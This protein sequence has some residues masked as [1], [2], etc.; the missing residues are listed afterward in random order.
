[1]VIVI[2]QTASTENA[3]LYNEKKVEQKAAV[4]FHS[5][6]TKAINPFFF[7]KSH[8]L[9]EL[10]NIEKLNPRVKNKCLHISV[11]PSADDS[12]KLNNP[13]IRKEIDQFMQHMGYGNQTYFVYKHKDLERTHF[14]IVSTRIDK[15]SGKKV[16]DNHERQKAQNFIKELELRHL[17]D[18]RKRSEK[19]VFKFSAQ[20]R[21]I[22]QS[23]ESLFYHINQMSEV[24]SK[25]LY[26]ETLKLFNVEIRKS[27]RGH[28]VLVTDGNGKVI[29]YPIRLSK[30]KEKPNFYQVEKKTSIK[31]RIAT[32]KD[33]R[34]S[35][36]FKSAF[37]KEL[38]LQI[39][40]KDLTKDIS[41]QYR[42]KRKS[43]RK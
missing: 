23:L 43:K 17:L 20:S 2:H 10:T 33:E 14:H 32:S 6:N 25:A 9:K 30:F 34:F 8:R 40:K 12:L 28:I 22:K 27:G 1:M 21:N 41:K 4:F 18:N 13:I 31:E 24:N 42:L 15:Q 5:R 26:N 36:G 19:P 3:F 38:L 35:Q 7:D 16:K 11:N 29:R 37:M 39:R